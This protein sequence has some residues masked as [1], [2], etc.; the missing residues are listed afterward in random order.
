MKMLKC[1]STWSS[2]TSICPG[3]PASHLSVLGLKDSSDVSLDMT[4]SDQDSR[5]G[6]F[7]QACH[8][9]ISYGMYRNSG[10][11]KDLD[12]NTLEI[13]RSSFSNASSFQ[14][15]ASS[16]QAGKMNHRLYEFPGLRF[17]ICCM[18]SCYV[19]VWFCSIN[20]GY[21]TT[22][23]SLVT[24]KVSFYLRCLWHI[25]YWELLLNYFQ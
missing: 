14:V 15:I 25:L 21:F 10:C 24:L 18:H 3:D 17:K 9:S 6:G 12:F 23:N 5:Y 16:E 11:Y 19:S 13:T 1:S 22:V 2:C 7:E 8:H 20:N 4:A